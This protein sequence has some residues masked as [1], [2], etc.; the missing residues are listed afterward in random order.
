MG[1]IYLILPTLLVILVSFLIVRGG[2]I[3]LMMTGIDEEKAKF[4]SLSAFSRAGF[5]TKEAELIMNNPQRRRIITWLII[6][7][8]AGIVAVIVTA[9]SSIASSEGYQLAIVISVLIVGTYLVYKLASKRGFT[10]RWE[11]F[12]E[13]RLIKSHA[14]DE[15]MT[16]DL[17]HFIEGYGLVRTT[18]TTDSPFVGTSISDIKRLEKEVQILGI[19]RG[20]EW[21]PLPEMKEVITDGDKF[22]I[23][24]RLNALKSMFGGLD[25]HGF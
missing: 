11:R 14:F 21:I 12:I 9:T 6:L 4:Q 16:E 1:G 2:A 10:R 13:N 20:K 19:E 23:Y 8:N 7:G 15:G 18:I 25:G 5:T 22:V 17:L 3:A 24:G